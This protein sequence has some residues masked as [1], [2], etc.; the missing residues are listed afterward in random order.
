[1]ASRPPAIAGDDV[2][3]STASPRRIFKSG[4]KHV[5]ALLLVKKPLNQLFQTRFALRQAPF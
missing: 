3:G 2:C 1:M 5:A 4:S